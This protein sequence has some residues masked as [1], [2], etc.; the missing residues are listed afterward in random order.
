M[1]FIR[2]IKS[3]DKL[4]QKLIEVPVYRIFTHKKNFNDTNHTVLFEIKVPTDKDPIHWIKKGVCFFT[5]NI[6]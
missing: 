3:A 2:P 5:Q 4:Q 1:I 6:Y